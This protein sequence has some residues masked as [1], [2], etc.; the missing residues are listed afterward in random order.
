MLKP[1]LLG[2]LIAC[3]Y[4]GWEY[5]AYFARYH[6]TV[7]ALSAMEGCTTEEDCERAW[8]MF[9]AANGGK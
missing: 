2:L 3:C 1:G 7:R 9:Q 8:A 4:L 5:G 6:A